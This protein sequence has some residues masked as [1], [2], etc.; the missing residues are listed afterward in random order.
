MSSGDDTI[1][2]ERDECHLSLLVLAV[3]VVGL[4]IALVRA[5]RRSVDSVVTR[6]IARAVLTFGAPR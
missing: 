5:C 6:R 3:P 1:A 2:D 4:T